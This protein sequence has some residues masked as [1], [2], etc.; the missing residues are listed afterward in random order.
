MRKREEISIL[1]VQ[2]QVGGE[3]FVAFTMKV[4][5]ATGAPD[6][7]S[8]NYATVS[9]LKPAGLPASRLRTYESLKS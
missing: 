9:R 4:A 1:P 8:F 5:P 2:R 3:V 7:K 6:F